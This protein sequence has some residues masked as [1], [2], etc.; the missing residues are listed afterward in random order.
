[1]LP[2]LPVSIRAARYVTGQ[3]RKACIGGPQ[4]HCQASHGYVTIGT[5]LSCGSLGPCGAFLGLRCVLRSSRMEPPR[6]TPGASSPWGRRQC[7]VAV[8]CC[9]RRGQERGRC[10]AYGCRWQ[11]RALM[12]PRT[13]LSRRRGLARA[14]PGHRRTPSSGTTYLV[15]ARRRNGALGGSLCKKEPRPWGQPHTSKEVADPQDSGYVAG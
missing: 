10:N 7:G 14:A 8:L 1:M 6:I 5:L 15:G 9:D 13:L 2:D 11:R 4:H 3:L 12:C